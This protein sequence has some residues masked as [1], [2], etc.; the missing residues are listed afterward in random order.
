MSD[1]SDFIDINAE[2]KVFE[3]ILKED[4]YKEEKK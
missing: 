3:K 2:I 1:E 4:G